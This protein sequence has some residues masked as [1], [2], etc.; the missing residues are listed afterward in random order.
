MAVA[1]AASARVSATAKLVWDLERLARLVTAPL[2]TAVR[3]T[4]EPASAMEAPADWVPAVLAIPAMVDLVL[5]SALASARVLV[6][7]ARA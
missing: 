7:L 2:A 5:G 3:V 1:P 4:V 6:A